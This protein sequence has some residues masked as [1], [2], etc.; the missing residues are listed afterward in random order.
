M[1]ASVLAACTAFVIW[2]T[3]Y[4]LTA[5]WVYRDARRHGFDGWL[6]VSL[7]SVLWPAGPFLWLVVRGNLH[8]APKGWGSI[9]G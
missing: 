1:G 6:A 9:G 5:R 4:G 8:L 7:V 3:S 2:L